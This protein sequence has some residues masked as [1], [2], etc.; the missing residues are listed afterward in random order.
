MSLLRDAIESLSGAPRARTLTIRAVRGAPLRSRAR[1]TG[2][3]RAYRAA[4]ATAS[5]HFPASAG[6]GTRAAVL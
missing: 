4:A 1:A 2:V 6:R 3:A 5:L